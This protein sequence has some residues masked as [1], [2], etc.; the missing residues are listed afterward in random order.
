MELRA[1][2]IS[3][4]LVS[5]VGYRA[6]LQEGFVCDLLLPERLPDHH[7]SHDEHERSGRIHIET[8]Y[9]R[10]VFRLFPPLLVTLL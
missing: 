2:S 7:T 8:F 4:V 10:R 6:S 3:I 1:I 9:L 5:H